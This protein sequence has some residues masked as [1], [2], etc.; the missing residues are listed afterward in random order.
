MNI[1]RSC[2][3]CGASIALV[4]SDTLAI[5]ASIPAGPAN[6]VFLTLV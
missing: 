3:V 6:P 1:S 4:I 5:G 2:C